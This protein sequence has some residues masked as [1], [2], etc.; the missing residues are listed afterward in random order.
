MTTATVPRRREAPDAS[1][2]APVRGARPGLILTAL[3]LAM[4]AFTVAQTSVVPILPTLAGAYHLTTATVAWVMTANLLAAAVLTPLLGRM[5]DLYGR[6]WVLVLSVGGLVL[7]SGLAFSAHSGRR[8]D[9]ELE[10]D[11]RRA[12]RAHPAGRDVAADG[13]RVPDRVPRLRRARPRGRGGAVPGA[14]QAERRLI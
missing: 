14:G 11:Q 1:P 3:V 6:K 8:G 2:A 9:P 4:L 10:D 5:G 12:A 13:R 7:G